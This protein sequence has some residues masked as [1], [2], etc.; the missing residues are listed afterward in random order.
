V[1]ELATALYNKFNDSTNE[2]YIDVNGRFYR[3]E[4]PPKTAYPYMV[5][6]FITTIPEEGFETQYEQVRVQFDLFSNKASSSE[7]E[8]MYIHLK[9]LYDW[10]SLTLDGYSCVYMKRVLARTFKDPD[11]N[12]WVYNVD[13]LVFL[14][15][16]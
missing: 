6:K 10:C 3:Q 1:K 12:D 2:I 14:E 15:K 7:V 5:Y 13:Y 9:D 8:T 11:T 4:A 16:N